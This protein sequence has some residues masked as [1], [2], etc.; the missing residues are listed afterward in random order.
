MKES[1]KH[2]LDDLMSEAMGKLGARLDCE[3]TWYSWPC[4]FPSTSGPRGGIG[5]QAI[6][7]FQVFGFEGGPEMKRIKYCGGIWRPWDGVPN[8]WEQRK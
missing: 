7:T 5:G 4:A 6:T 1:A 2:N 3:V 8:G